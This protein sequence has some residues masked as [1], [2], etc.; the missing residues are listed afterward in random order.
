MSTSQVPVSRKDLTPQ[1]GSMTPLGVKRDHR[2]EHHMSSAECAA[3]IIALMG[4][5]NAAPLIERIKEQKVKVFLDTYDRL[6]FVPRERKLRA[7]AEFVAQ[8]KGRAGG[9]SGGQPAI[10]DFAASLLRNTAKSPQEPASGNEEGPTKR[11]WD[12][13]K[14][15]KPAETASYLEKLR[16]AQS[17]AIL[18]QLEPDIAASIL[19]ELPENIATAAMA[20]LAPPHPLQSRHLKAIE[21]VLVRDF[22]S[23]ETEAKKDDDAAY[24]QVVSILSSMMTEKRE[25]FLKL[26]SEQAPTTAQ[27]IKR[28]MVTFETLPSRLPVQAVPG[29]MRDIDQAILV[30]CIRYGGEKYRESIDFLLGNISKRM[31]EQLRE[32]AEELT[33]ISETDGE[34]ALVAVVALVMSRSKEGGITLIAPPIEQQEESQVEDA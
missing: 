21:D 2:D 5:E 6:G 31:A 4:P 7:I 28:Q 24:E 14:A 20:N 23:V 33:S 9:M 25:K 8:L 15:R 19:S 17:A 22:L 18:S 13:L 34:S 16:A 10:R 32:Q 12:E 27:R 29:I 30:K 11:V 3:I 26:L 1:T